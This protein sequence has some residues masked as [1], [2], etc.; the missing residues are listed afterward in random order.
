MSVVKYAAA[1]FPRNRSLSMK[2][3]LFRSESMKMGCTVSTQTE[4]DLCGLLSDV[5]SSKC[6]GEIVPAKCDVKISLISR[7][8]RLNDVF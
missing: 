8:L 5:Y 1:E 2:H 6:V 7:V 4:W 3:S